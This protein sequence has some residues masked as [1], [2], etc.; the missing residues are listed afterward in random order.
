MRIRDFDANDVNTDKYKKLRY[1]KNTNKP[2]FTLVGQKYYFDTAF[3]QQLDVMFVDTKLCE[4]SRKQKEA[5][6]AYV[7]A[8]ESGSFDTMTEQLDVELGLIDY[9]ETEEEN[10]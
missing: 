9:S 5:W 6:N 10:K 4:M 1:T 8:V 7:S 2:C 3:I